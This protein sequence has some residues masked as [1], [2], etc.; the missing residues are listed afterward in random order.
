MTPDRQQRNYER[1]VARM[2]G[3]ARGQAF[4]V[5]VG[6]ALAMLWAC[7]AFGAPPPQCTLPPRSDTA[8]DDR[9]AALERRVAELCER[10]DRPAGTGP[11]QSTPSVAAGLEVQ[12]APP[13]AYT[14]VCGSNGCGVGPQP[15]TSPPPFQGAF[16][17]AGP[18]TGFQGAGGSCV[19]GSC[20]AAAP[21]GGFLRGGW[22]RGRR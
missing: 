10:L 8:T 2:D 20:G 5:L 21:A 6:V 14:A 11:T 16:Y 12:S 18:F 7:G 17:S 22:F 19:G 9:L 1:E 13:A 15:F 4:A 3:R